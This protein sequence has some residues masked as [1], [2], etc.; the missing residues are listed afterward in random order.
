MHTV[1]TPRTPTIHNTLL[2]VTYGAENSYRRGLT[3]GGSGGGSQAPT[4]SLRNE[5]PNHQFSST[6][7]SPVPDT[8]VLLFCRISI[9]FPAATTNCQPH[10]KQYTTQSRQQHSISKHRLTH[11]SSVSGDVTQKCWCAIIFTSFFRKA[12]LLSCWVM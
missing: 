8:S 2:T 10:G 7:P 5:S 3:Q 4:L 1:A 12:I 6:S 11:V 9:V